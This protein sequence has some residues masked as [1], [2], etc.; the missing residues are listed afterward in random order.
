MAAGLAGCGGS[1]AASSTTRSTPT[2]TALAA[3]SSQP[4]VGSTSTSSSTSTT[5]SAAVKRTRHTDPPSTT[6]AS[7]AST[8]T[9]TVTTTSIA[10]TPVTPKYQG[11]SPEGCLTAAGLNRARAAAEPGVWEAN[12]G[13][14]ALNNRL[15]IVFLA[16]PLKS[17]KVAK[18]Y[19]QSLTVV[20]I[21]ASGGDWVASAAL[22]S[23]LDS[24]VAK[25]AACMAQ[26]GTAKSK[27]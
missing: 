17:P 23:H 9:T 8:V 5:T 16:G 20:E 15:Q 22:P 10:P 11:P 18:V 14:S 4:A 26:T 6:T 3:E 2:T 1:G 7:Q 24:Q 13:L 25:A 27:S 19:A 21:A 12:A